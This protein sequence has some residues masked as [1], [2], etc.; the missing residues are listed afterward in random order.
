MG[1]ASRRTF[2]KGGAALAGA[3]VLSRRSRAGSSA[4]DAVTTKLQ[5]FDYADIQLLEGPMR[6]QFEQNHALFLALSEDALLKPFRQKAG[7]PAPGE[8][9][10]GWYSWSKDF[11]PPHNMTGYIPGHSFGQYLSGLARAYATTRDSPTRQK[12][13]RLVEGFGKTVTEKFY[14]DYPLPAYT[15]DKTNCGLIDAHQFAGDPAALSVLE[16]ATDAVLPHL[17]SK[18]LSRPEMEARP[19]PNIAYTWDETYTL[20]ENFL[21]AY[22]RSGNAR[23]RQLAERFLEDDTYFDPLADGKNIL[24]GLHAYSHVNALCSASQ[25][26][27]V[28]NSEKHL[29]AA[30]NGFGFV[31]STQSFATG[32]WGPNETFRTPGSGDLGSSLEKTHA[33]FETP[34]GAYGHFKIARYLMRVTG[35]S[36]YGDSME[37]VLY[38]TILGA[39][40]IRPD[41]TSFYYS[42]YNN[43]AS[44]VYY[45]QKWPCCSGT[46]PQITAD[47]GIS[48]YFRSED[49]VY[50]NL[51]VPS[52]LKWRVG[53][54]RYSLE[55]QT[56]YPTSPEIRIQVG[57]ERPE[58]FTIYLR[59]PE[60]AGGKTSIAVNGKNLSLPVR[61]GAFLAVAREWKDGDRIE[62]TIDMPFRLES[63]DPQHPHDVALLHGPVTLFA[64]GASDNVFTRAQL[65][66][67]TQRGSE[68]TVQSRNQRVRFLPFAAIHDEKYRLYQY[69]IA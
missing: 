29:R 18:A 41:G 16:H 22:K 43:H 51:F 64:I 66:A 31:L 6:E 67:A 32:G 55:Q 26:Y 44:K 42:D 4:A 28:L 45:E 58:K 2:L 40:P 20:P 34:C 53:T 12:I 49:G 48:S 5:Q 36:R 46:F 60:W 50:V 24:P 65:L 54:A 47:Y 11:D 3:Q 8:E 63:I 23:Y 25:A 37:R 56:Q 17:P 69:V 19:H 52:R 39:K 33:S 35:D 57:A 7:L 13:H 68:Y 15:F 62:Y 38:N 30:R 59:V 27:L 61:S 9:M 14:V 10:G 21:L 1:K